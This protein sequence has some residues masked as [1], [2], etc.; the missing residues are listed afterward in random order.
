MRFGVLISSFFC[1][2]A[3]P[4]L[5]KAQECEKILAAADSYYAK[6]EYAKAMKEYMVVLTDCPGSNYGGAKDKLKD[7]KKKIQE[8]EDF[9][10]C[11]SVEGCD[12]YLSNW[13]NGR[14]SV[15]TRAKRQKLF[16]DFQNEETAFQNCTSL[17]AC[18][19]YLRKYPNGKHVSE[20]NIRLADFNK[21][22]ELQRRLDSISRQKER[23]ARVRAYMQIRNVEFANIDDEGNFINPYGFTRYDADIRILRPRIAYDGLID[24]PK[25]ITVYCKIISPQ[26]EILQNEDSPDG[27]TYLSDIWVQ[28]GDDNKIQLPGWGT[29]FGDYYTPGDYV[30]EIWFENKLILHHTFTVHGKTN[31]LSRG[32]WKAALKK[33]NEN[34][35]QMYNTSSY[36]GQIDGGNRDGVGMYYWTDKDCYIG[37]FLSGVQHGVGIQIVMNENGEISNC[38]QCK[39][40][41]GDWRSGKKSGK[42]TCY[43]RLGNVIYYGRFSDNAPIDNYPQKGFSN[44]KFESIGYSNGDYYVGETKDGKPHGLG[45]YIWSNGNMWYGNW[46][47]GEKY[48]EGLLL[49]YD[50]SVST[51]F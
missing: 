38:T 43:D 5:T 25:N 34:V 28:P 39:Y 10:N 1:L 17:E 12:R 14:Y 15:K 24:E 21:E 7:C 48:K 35:T 37:N 33:C 9:R 30:L 49:M 4:M 16:A 31:N 51:S 20:V 23:E 41:V 6:H 36:K 46:M 29:S 22:L 18:E 44:Y 3:S 50:G 13:P 8:D 45:V 40:Y 2:L 27:Y 11:T 42:G 32:Q 26:G 47:N 19:E